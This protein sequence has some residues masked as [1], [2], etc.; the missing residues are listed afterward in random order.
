MSRQEAEE[1]AR[2]MIEEGK[3]QHNEEMIHRHLWGA[4]EKKSERSSKEK[5]IERKLSKPIT[6]NFSDVPLKQALDDIRAGRGLNIYVDTPALEDAGIDLSCPINFKAEDISLKSALNMLLHSAHLTFVIKDEALCVT[7]EAGA[8]GKRM[9]KV[10]NV[11]DLVVSGCFL[12][13]HDKSGKE[14]EAKA[15]A[16][17]TYEGKLVS[18]I[19]STVQPSS[20]YENG[21]PGTIDY[22]PMT[23]S[24]V[25]NQTADNHGEIQDLLN[26]LRRLRKQENVKKLMKQ[27]HY[28]IRTGQ[29][30][31]AAFLAAQAFRIDPEMVVADPLVYK[32]HLQ[33]W[34][35]EAPA[36]SKTAVVV[37]SAGCSGIKL[38]VSLPGVDATVVQALDEMLQGVELKPEPKACTK[39]G[40]TCPAG[41][42]DCAKCCQGEECTCARSKCDCK[43]GGKC[44]CADGKCDCGNSCCC[45]DGKCSSHACTKAL[46][47]ADLWMGLCQ[48]LMGGCCH[49]V[50]VSIDGVRMLFDFNV[51]GTH[52]RLECNG[53]DCHLT[54]CPVCVE[55]E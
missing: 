19:T 22:H 33:N 38:E 13:T 10:Y 16:T 25:V 27:C 6:M 31:A 26:S 55:Q 40:C 54:V 1:K 21:G 7:T 2:R 47:D 12:A 44:C 34:H 5:E 51:A 52:Y 41:C 36:K 9:T 37:P 20:W 24:L 35:D 46:G 48:A 4:I 3:K 42:K 15:D 39:S 28:Y 49:D 32:M 29:C 17:S 53:N 11:A 23:M 50:A 18:L 14:C 30:G 45:K 8:C 43:N